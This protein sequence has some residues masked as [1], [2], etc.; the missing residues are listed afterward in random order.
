MRDVVVTFGGRIAL[1]G[2]IIVGDV[3]VARSLG[4]EG[5]G[6]FALVLALS[7][8]GAVVLGL[9]LDRSL[10][11]YAARSLDVAQRAFANGLLWTTVVGALGVVAILVLY[12]PSPT[13][14]GT[15]PLAPIMPPLTFPQLLL[16]ALALPLELAYSIGLVG[17]VGRQRVIAYNVLRFVRRALLTVLLLAVLFISR[18]DL[19]LVLWLNLAALAI[20]AAGIGWA[21]A[22][23]RMLGFRVSPRLLVGQLSFG[24]RT[25]V[26]AIAERLHYRANTFLLTAFVSVAATGVFSVALALAETLWYLPSALGLVLFSRAVRPGSDSA[27]IASAMTRTML[28]LVIVVALPLGLAAPTLIEIVYGAPFRDAGPALQVLLPGV[29][30]YSIVALLSN[31][32][33]A[34]G[35]P[36]RAAAI[37]IA[38]L[39]V[40]LIGNLV[41]IPSAGMFG[42]ALASTVSYTA[43][44][45]LIVL[46]YCRISGQSMRETLVL[47]RTDIVTRWAQLR[48]LAARPG[49]QGA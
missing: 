2:A 12:G 11:V 1:T 22:R 19:E 30:A 3:I 8:L 29:V 34:R 25:V 41:L 13:G 44:A 9:G 36:G 39:A 49:P 20:T 38:G 27:G 21:A 32:I 37:L 18:L 10:A 26:G 31:Y 28:A 35:A 48:R 17:L 46:L 24:G 42:A 16:G 5:K 4:P 47:K 7:S 6:A 23:A 40:N 33:I 15:G 45:S 14:G 43:T